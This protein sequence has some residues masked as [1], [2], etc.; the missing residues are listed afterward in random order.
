[1]KVEH[2]HKLGVAEA[3]NRINKFGDF[4][5]E[6]NIALKWTS[7][8]TASVSGK[9]TVVAIDATVTVSDNNVLIEGKDPGFLFRKA[10]EN[11]LKEKM[12]EYLA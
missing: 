1:M 4:L 10:A 6:Q 11:F 8:T 5:A 12:K 3:K 9:Y 7:D 2:N